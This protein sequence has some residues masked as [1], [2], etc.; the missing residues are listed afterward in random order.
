[1][2]ET[3]KLV[4]VGQPRI[5]RQSFPS[6]GLAVSATTIKGETGIWLHGDQGWYPEGKWGRNEFPH[7]HIAG[8]KS[9]PN[10]QAQAPR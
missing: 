2:S 9:L 10:D 8:W 4:P 1:M 3:E 5:V 7:D 6:Y